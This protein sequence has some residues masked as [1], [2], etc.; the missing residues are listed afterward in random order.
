MVNCSM[1]TSCNM[2][3]PNTDDFS[4]YYFHRVRIT[5]TVIFRGIIEL[6]SCVLID[7]ALIQVEVWVNLKADML[8]Q[9]FKGLSAAE[10]EIFWRPYRNHGLDGALRLQLPHYLSLTGRDTIWRCRLVKV[11]VRLVTTCQLVQVAARTLCL[12]AT[13]RVGVALVPN[14]S[15]TIKHHVTTN[16]RDIRQ[17]KSPEADID[18]AFCR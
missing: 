17:N 1:C 18:P 10:S 9:T 13:T 6:F 7:A 4:P 3:C 8:L 2:R 15:I 5:K 12:G 14:D 16:K 11:L